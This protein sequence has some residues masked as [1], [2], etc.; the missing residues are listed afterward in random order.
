MT[1]NGFTIVE[2]MLA[3]G[4]SSLIVV[5]LVTSSGTS[6]RGFAQTEDTLSSS[7][8]AQLLLAY[9]KA[10]VALADSPPHADPTTAPGLGPVFPKSWFHLSAMPGR[11]N[12]A[13]VRY[14]AEE[15]PQPIPA[16]NPIMRVP[17]DHPGTR[18]ALAR[19]ARIQNA[20]AWIDPKSA[21][22]SSPPFLGMTVRNGGAVSGVTYTF[23]EKEKSV[24][25]SGPEG[26]VTIGAGSM[27]DFVA[28]PYIELLIPNPGDDM[29]LEVLKSWLEVEIKVQAPQKN[30]PIAKKPVTLKTRLFP[31]YLHAV[32]RGLSPF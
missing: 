17:Q 6:F 21:G 3:V 32:V 7:R 23:D 11:D 2:A 24:I 14:D 12:F 29:P 22:Q 4:L 18:V 28:T 30:D 16:E 26:K 5:L 10:D 27:V 19:L 13:I 9:L 8:H 1:R 20:M 31:R 15:R 25:R